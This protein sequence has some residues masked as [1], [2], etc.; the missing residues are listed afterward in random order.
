MDSGPCLLTLISS[1]SR[2]CCKFQND[3]FN[4]FEHN[5]GT[6]KVVLA[7]IQCVVCTCEGTLLIL[8][9]RYM[10]IKCY[11]AYITPHFK[12]YYAQYYAFLSL[13]KGCE[14]FWVIKLR[15][16]LGSTFFPLRSICS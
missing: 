9:T 10:F 8:V 14:A 1:G 7:Y 16:S 5:P 6:T 4:V 12:R 3:Y 13:E 15:T 11:Y 2:Y